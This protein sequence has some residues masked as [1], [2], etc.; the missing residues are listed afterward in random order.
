MYFVQ[1]VICTKYAFC[2][3]QMSFPFLKLS[4][5]TQNNLGLMDHKNISNSPS[6]APFTSLCEKA[7]VPAFSMTVL[8][9]KMPVFFD[10]SHNTVS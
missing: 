6:S 3:K 5:K 8:F 4:T 7:T 1:N 10:I 9:T 2:T